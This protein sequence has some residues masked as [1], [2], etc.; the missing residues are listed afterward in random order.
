MRV[1]KKV[2]YGVRV[3][4]DL[5]LAYRRGRGPVQTAE[6]ALRQNIPE[7]YLEHLMTTLNKLGFVRSRRGPQGGHVLARPPEE[8]TLEMVVRSLEG[9]TA[10]MECLEDPSE[11]IFA[12][13]CTQRT[14]WQEVEAAIRGVLARTTIADLVRPYQEPAQPATPTRR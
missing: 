1:P 8:I 2:D 11:C 12:T 14:V 9:T 4:A 5:A 3:L 7:A 13:D 6:I 10:P